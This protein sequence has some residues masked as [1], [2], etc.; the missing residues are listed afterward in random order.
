MK[1]AADKND[2]IYAGQTLNG[3]MR[4]INNE[5]DNEGYTIVDQTLDKCINGDLYD[6]DLMNQ[7]AARECVDYLEIMENTEDPEARL[8]ILIGLAT[9]FTSLGVL[10]ERHRKVTEDVDS[11]V[12]ELGL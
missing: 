9:Q 10:M 7:V 6:V 11:P 12:P 5:H 3:R 2:I 8:K 1:I 4:A